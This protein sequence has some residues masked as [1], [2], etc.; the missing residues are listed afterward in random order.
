MVIVNLHGIRRIGVWEGVWDGDL[1][2]SLSLLSIFW[3]RT[4]R[5]YTG[6]LSV[7]SSNFLEVSA[8]ARFSLSS[9]SKAIKSFSR[10]ESSSWRYKSTLL[11]RNP[12]FLA[13]KKFSSLLTKAAS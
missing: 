10:T 4:L 12:Y 2:Y 3:I 8:I 7:C 9:S 11:R 6:S 13:I 5:E 1:P